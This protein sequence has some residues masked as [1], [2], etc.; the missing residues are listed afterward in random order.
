MTDQKS[1][2]HNAYPEQLAA[3]I[4]KIA[5]QSQRLITDFFARQHTF[6]SV[7][8]TDPMNVTSAFM[9]MTQNMLADLA[10]TTEAQVTLWLSHKNFW[11]STTARM[12]GAKEAPLVEPAADDHR[13]KDDA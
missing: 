13:F 6:T 3:T 5:E 1:E 11:Q 4:G 12:M 8:M 9:K 10:K 7:D 2:T